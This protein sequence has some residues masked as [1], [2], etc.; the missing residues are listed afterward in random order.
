MNY[1]RRRE[2]EMKKERE[3]I[4]GRTECDTKVDVKVPMIFTMLLHN[5]ILIFL[6]LTV[7]HVEPKGIRLV[8]FCGVT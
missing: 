1:I 6:H 2:G 5:Y 7:L 4:T 8:Q 3:G